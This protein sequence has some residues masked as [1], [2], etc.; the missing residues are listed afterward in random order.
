MVNWSPTKIASHIHPLV[1]IGGH[2]LVVKY[3]EFIVVLSNNLKL[4][5]LLAFNWSTWRLLLLKKNHKFI[6]EKKHLTIICEE[7]SREKYH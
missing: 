2:R 1:H 6:L 3:I 4:I 5:L 7:K